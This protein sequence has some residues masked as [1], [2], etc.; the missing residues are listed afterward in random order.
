MIPKK[1]NPIY[2]DE[3]PQERRR[4]L[5]SILSIDA[6]HILYD[7]SRPQSASDKKREK[8]DE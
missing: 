4:I 5:P 2:R 7:F 8:S 6:T 3:A 1:T